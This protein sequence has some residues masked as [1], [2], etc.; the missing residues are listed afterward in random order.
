MSW[1]IIYLLCA[2]QIILL[3]MEYYTFFNRGRLFIFC[4][5]IEDYAFLAWK[6]LNFFSLSVYGHFKSTPC[7]PRWSRCRDYHYVFCTV[8]SSDSAAQKSGG[9]VLKK[10]ETWKQTLVPVPAIIVICV[11][12]IKINQWPLWLLFF[13][14]DSVSFLWPLF[15]TWFKKLMKI[16]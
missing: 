1:K 2:F 7:T 9:K 3:C 13:P 6:I 12:H 16:L 10:H 5:G 15:N 14:E 4:F 11:T 8:H